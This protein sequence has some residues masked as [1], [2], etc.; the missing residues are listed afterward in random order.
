MSKLKGEDRL[1]LTYKCMCMYMR[2]SWYVYIFGHPPN[3]VYVSG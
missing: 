3:V 2:V 1:G